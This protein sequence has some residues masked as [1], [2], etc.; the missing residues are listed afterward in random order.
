[1]RTK[2]KTKKEDKTITSLVK[3]NLYHYEMLMALQQQ[4]LCLEA[5]IKILEARIGG[6]L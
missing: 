1:M 6:N 3:N 2:V 4:V 5:K